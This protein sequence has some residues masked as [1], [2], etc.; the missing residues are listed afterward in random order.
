MIALAAFDGV[1]GLTAVRELASSLNMRIYEP[2]PCM[3][4]TRKNRG[5]SMEFFFSQL[6]EGIKLRNVMCKGMYFSS[7]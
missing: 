3:L 5:Q 6:D 7:S 4:W 2:G 1:L